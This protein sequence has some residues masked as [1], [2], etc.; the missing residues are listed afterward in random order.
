MAEERRKEAE[1][2]GRISRRE[3]LK[4]AGLVVG[5]ATI[6]SMSLMNACGSTT[7]VTAGVSTVTKT[8][9]T[10]VGAGS[11]STVT[12][13]SPPVT[14][15][16]GAAG[17]L[18]QISVTIN[19]EVYTP[20]VD[21]SWDLQYLMHDVMGFI[22]IKTFCYRGACGSC[23]VIMDGRPILSCMTLAVNADGHKIETSNG[24][25][26]AKHPLV[27]A[28]IDFHCMQC[29]YCTPGFICTSKALLDR[30]PTPSNDEIMDALAGNLCRCGTYP[31]HILAINRAA[32]VL[33]G[34]S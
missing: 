26:I 30:N 5:G 3:F 27:Q 18:T 22:E 33:K 16:Q 4:D 15:T 28:Y 19:G 12:V 13:T 31:Q 34:G 2:K 23:T 25:A 10:S 21:P 9:T 20:F 11:T 7:T 29:G 1:E 24:I 6:G 32:T 8:V 14:V 17:P